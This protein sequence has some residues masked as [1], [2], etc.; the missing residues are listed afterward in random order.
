MLRI[1][2]VGLTGLAGLAGL[3][4]GGCDAG[5]GADVAQAP[6]ATGEQVVTVAFEIEGMHCTGCV[7][8]IEGTAAQVPGVVACRVSLEDATAQCDLRSDADAEAFIDR[9][10]RMGYVVRRA[11]PSSS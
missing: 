10:S 4:G 5:G 1:G 2:V 7:A 8:A 6:P 11:A 9:I 3:A